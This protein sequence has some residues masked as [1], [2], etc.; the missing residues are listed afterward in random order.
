MEPGE[1]IEQTMPVWRRLVEPVAVHIAD[2]MEG[3]LSFGSTE[4]AA[5]LP[6][7]AGME[8]MLRPMLR[9][10][11]ASMF[12]LQ[13]GQGLGHPATEVVGATDIGLPLSEPG[14]ARCRPT[15]RPSE[16]AW[17]SRAKMSLSIWPCGSALGNDSSPRLAGCDRRC[18]LW[19]SSTRVASRSTPRRWSR[20]SAARCQQLED[21]TSSLEGGLFEPQKTPEQLATLERLE[22]MLALVE[23]WVDEVVT[24]ATA[25]M[26]SA[27][28]L[29]ELCAGLVP[30]EVRPRRRSPRWWDLSCGRAGCVMLQ[31]CGRRC[32]TP[33]GWMVGTP[34]GRIPTSCPHQPILTIHWALSPARPAPRARRPGTS[35][36]PSRSCSRARA[37]KATRIR[38]ADPA[39][40]GLELSCRRTLE[41]W[42]APSA[43]QDQLRRHYLDH[44]ATG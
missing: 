9:T 28:A 14:T 42:S 22:T 20:P 39:T 1:W 4:E 19:S 15:S 23:G 37:P 16:R 33:A 13:L 11:G 21:L 29:A 43:E 2:A 26:P 12:G 6:G 32:A 30:P 25:R 41:T 31:T 27:A 40:G 34:S 36:L 7:M 10:S 8:K 3:A 24:Q 38:A 44:L 17:N 18:W 5:G 35:T